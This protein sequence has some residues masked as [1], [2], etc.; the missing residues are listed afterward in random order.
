VAF[1]CCRVKNRGP[2]RTGLIPCATDSSRHYEM[3]RRPGLHDQPDQPEH[4]W[5]Y[6]LS[7]IPCSL[8][9]LP[10]R[11]QLP[12]RRLYGQAVKV[13]SRL[14]TGMEGRFSGSILPFGNI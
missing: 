8:V 5:A 10:G 12:A 7:P 11:G 9:R 14:L 2:C 4:T 13:I 6:S 1:C 3:N